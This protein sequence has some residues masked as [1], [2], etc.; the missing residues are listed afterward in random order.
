MDKSELK[1]TNKKQRMSSKDDDDNNSNASNQENDDYNDDNDNVDYEYEYN[2][3]EYQYEEEI[4]DKTDKTFS[5][6][7]DSIV[8]LENRK[9]SPTINNEDTNKI[10]QAYN[11][12]NNFIETCNLDNTARNELYIRKNKDILLWNFTHDLQCHDIP[13]LFDTQALYESLSQLLI[14]ISTDASLIKVLMPTTVP[15][16]T[17]SSSSS[18]SA[19]EEASLLT[20]CHL[21]KTT[22]SLITSLLASDMASPISKVYLILSY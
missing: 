6:F 13:H 5:S 19:V 21:M 7:F 18:S 3:D 15:S 1:L 12:I 17:H 2:D 8:T 11:V 4:V 16:H 9:N 10:T 20:C 14:T 22:D